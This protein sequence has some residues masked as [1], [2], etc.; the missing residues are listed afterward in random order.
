MG[1]YPPLVNLLLKHF[2]GIKSQYSIYYG[3]PLE[4]Y[5]SVICDADETPSQIH[6][7][8]VSITALPTWESLLHFKSHYS[9]LLVIPLLYY[10]YCCYTHI[11]VNFSHRAEWAPYK[12]EVRPQFGDLSRMCKIN[13]FTIFYTQMQQHWTVFFYYN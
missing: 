8:I 11:L 2:F 5:K 7:V 9:N 3:H 1:W 13:Q 12:P 6:N 4:K 10:R